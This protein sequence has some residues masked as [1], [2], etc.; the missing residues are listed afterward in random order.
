MSRNPESRGEHGEPNSAPRRRRGVTLSSRLAATV[1]GVGIASM[2]VA[3]VVGLDT[4]QTLGRTIVNDSLQALRSAG[5]AQ[6]AAQMD[7]YE[8]LA[9]QLASSDQTEVAIKDFSLALAEL[10]SATGSELRELRQRL[11]RAYQEKY[12]KPL[13]EAGETVQVSD[14]L[15]DNPAALYLQANYSVP[16]ELISDPIAV[17]D[18]ADGSDWSAAHA[19][20]HPGFRNTVIQGGLIDL[21]LVGATGRIVYSA[22][23]GPDLGTSVSVGPYSGSIIARAADAAADSDDGIVTDLSYYRTAPG[24]PIGAAAAAVRAEGRVIGTVVLTYAAEVYTQQ[25]TSL[26]AATKEVTSD[27]DELETPTDLYLFG[28]DGKTRSDPQA[29]LLDPQAFLDTSSAAGVLTEEER[30]V[31]ER[32]GTTILV[33]PAVDATVNAALDGVTEVGSATSMTGADVVSEAEPLEVDDVRWWTVVEISSDAATSP[34]TAFRKVL[35]FGSATFLVV[36]AFVAVAWA[37]SFMRPVRV[38]SDRLGTSAIAQGAAATLDPVTIPDRS[39]VEFHRLVGSLTAMGLSLRHQQMELR[40]ARAQRVHVLESMLPSS[41]AQRI[42]RGDV[43]ALD[44]V[45]SATVVVVVVLGLG[46]LVETHPGGDRQLID[47]LHATVDDIALE[48][49]L[50]RIKVVGDSYFGACG[51]DR[52]YIDH[53]P[54]TV[55]FA[56][57]V[58][59]AV[60]ALARASSA[61]LATAIGINT[62]P[63]TVGMSGGT[64]LVYDVWGPTVTT[65]H[66]LARAAHADEIIVTEAT[67]ARLPEEI[68]V[69]HWRGGAAP[70]DAHRQVGPGGDLWAVVVAPDVR[71]VPAGTG[72][73]Q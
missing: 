44:E 48:Q 28:A 60:N 23:K 66:A 8:S 19:R 21:Y 30:A 22:S 38:I 5:S 53:A 61:P 26:V 27:D 1:L 40:E 4:G 15:S 33:L 58:A 37:K 14:I 57:R 52:P 31:I 7:Y 39:P 47:E 25:L 9:E 6:V 41:V 36:L 20:F 68:E 17:S 67:R 45:P 55:V 32:T 70:A 65:A 12:F 56:E 73:Q 49:G 46:R 10:P 51:H 71:D 24:T 2:L 64:R 69:T 59:E 72:A 13:E 42:A 11:L 16:D 35:L 50:D 18:A 3:T 54:R 34:F 29:Y 63:V 43:E 62:G